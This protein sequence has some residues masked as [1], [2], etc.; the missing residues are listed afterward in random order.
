MAN[1]LRQ[2]V[3]NAL[4]FAQAQVRRLVENHPGFYPLYTD[5]GKW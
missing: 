1:D 3:V 4:S 2:H 5:Q